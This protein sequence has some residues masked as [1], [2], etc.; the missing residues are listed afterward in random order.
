MS[1]PLSRPQLKGAAQAFCD[2][3]AEKKDVDYIVSLFSTTTPISAI[4]YGDPAQA[5]F[6][7]RTF[8]GQDGLKEYFGAITHLL[9]YEDMSFSEY[10]VDEEARKVAV[11]GKAKFTWKETGK[12]WD[13]T[14]SYVLDF[15]EGG[16]LTRY[17]VWSDTGSAYMASRKD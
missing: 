10:V 5:I 8:H 1:N 16:K 15:D 6:L 3:F 12:S 13:E 14:F 9:S 2:A 7:G 11:K 17:Q 4:E